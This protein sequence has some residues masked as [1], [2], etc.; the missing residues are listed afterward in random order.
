MAIHS[1]YDSPYVLINKELIREAIENQDLK[2]Y[3]VAE[4][5]GIH[6]TTLRRWLSGHITRVRE[7]HAQ[8]IARVL[9]LPLEQITSPIKN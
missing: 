4:M 1:V 5:A 8:N 6:K 7:V 3:W 2:C 9:T